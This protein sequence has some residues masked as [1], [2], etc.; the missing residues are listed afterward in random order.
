MTNAT[1]DPDSQEKTFRLMYRS[2]DLIPPERRKAALGE[3]FSYARS[4][5]KKQH[6]SGALLLSDDRFV[7]T[8]EGEEEAVRELFAR[9]E[10]DPRHDSVVVL[11]AQLVDERVFVRWAMAKVSEQGESDIP[12]IAHTDGIARAAARGD[13]P[14]GQDRILDVMREAARG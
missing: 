10:R 14:P 4:N 7:Q 9:I 11:D 8:L 3:L 6:I 5:N 2:R 13:A 1:T 12:L